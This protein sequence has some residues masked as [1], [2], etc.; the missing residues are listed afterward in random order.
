MP[1]RCTAEMK[2]DALYKCF[3]EQIEVRSE[4]NG[5]HEKPEIEWLIQDIL[6]HGQM[7][8]VG[9]WDDAGAPVLAYGFSRW[10]AVSEINKRKLT[11]QKLEIKCVYIQCN[12]QGAFV[13]NISENRMRNPTTP[14]DDAH[15]IQRLFNWE[16]DEKDVAQIYFPTA[17][18]KS[19]IEE[20]VKWVRGRLDFIKL[21]PEAE[22][23]MK[24]GRLNET[25]AQAIT[26]LSSTQQK[27]I[28]KKGGK[29][30]AKDVKASIPKKSRA[31]KPIPMDP[32]LR[33]RIT[34]VTESADWDSFDE[35]K[36]EKICISA[37]ALAA[38][39]DFI[40]EEK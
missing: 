25:A 40:E 31:A 22:K 16:M 33:R 12:E 7:Q 9:I 32:E 5:R 34:A 24:E 21:T 2:R 15:N 8:P 18:T 4:L 30:T 10:R 1:A 39:K 27:E 3:P 26:K 11:P 28:L 29:L 23:A 17:K 6:A 37:T 14:I 20:G 19:E 35:K 13:R 38:L 36:T